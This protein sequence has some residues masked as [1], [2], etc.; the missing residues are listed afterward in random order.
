MKPTRLLLLLLFL[1][2][3]AVAPAA[4]ANDDKPRLL[5]LGKKKGDDKTADGANREPVVV[6]PKQIPAGVAFNF[7][8]RPPRPDDPWR[9]LWGDP[10]FQRRFI[11]SFTTQSE[12]EPQVTGTN[13][14]ALLRA[15]APVMREDPKLAAYILST[16]VN[17]GGNAAFDYMLGGLHFQ[18]GDWEKAASHY[19]VA[20]SK[21]RDYRRAHKNLA[22]CQMKAGAFDQA[23]EPFTRAVELGDR[24]ATVFG[25]MGFCHLNGQNHL[26]AETAYRQAMLFQPANKDWKLGLIKSLLGQERL[27]E[28]NALLKPMLRADPGAAELWSLQAGIYVQLEQPLEAAVNY[29]IVRKLGAAKPAMLMML[30]DLYMTREAKDLALPAYLEAIEKQGV[31]DLSRAVRAAAILVSRAAFDEAEKLF[32]AIRA[33]AGGALPGGEELKLL[34]LES[35]VVMARGDAV[36]AVAVLEQVIE[37]DPLDAEALL[38]VGDHHL[39]RE[40]LE[41]AEFRYELAGKIAGHEADAFVKLAQ[42]KVKQQKYDRAIELLKQAQKVKPRDSVQRYLEA[43]ERLARS[44]S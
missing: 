8:V 17:E 28:A 30:G 35:K 16:N 39:R 36:K 42:V 24:D 11:S 37:R 3:P 15:I 14:V 22:F 19:Q 21:F 26:A 9:D 29:E 4:D 5:R 1:A 18:F 7:S 44:A 32:A 13:E 38:L 20:V 25:L 2:G 34:K 33:K 41:K 40:E 43:V 23:L 27:A 12:I 6:L 31:G 10:E